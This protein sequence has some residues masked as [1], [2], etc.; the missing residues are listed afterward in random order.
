VQDV[1]FQD[2]LSNRRRDTARVLCSSSKVPFIIVLSGQ[3]IQVVLAVVASARC[4]V[5]G[6]SLE[7]KKRYN[8]QGTSFFQ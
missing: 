7:W 5:S 8:G 6:K 4:G 3:N 2:N 1:E